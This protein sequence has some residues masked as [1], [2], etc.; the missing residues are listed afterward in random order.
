MIS[1][2][3]LKVIK[4]L[5]NEDKLDLMDIIWDDIYETNEYPPIP[6]N[7][8]RILN[9]RMAKYERGESSFKSW[10]EIKRKYDF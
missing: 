1:E 4:A 10:E 8:K 7:H 3:N 5:S 2:Q 9:E 6:E